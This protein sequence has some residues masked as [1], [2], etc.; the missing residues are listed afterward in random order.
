M[1]CPFCDSEVLAVLPNHLAS[2]HG[3]NYMPIQREPHHKGFFCTPCGLWF[4]TNEECDQ[5]ILEHGKQCLIDN[6]FRW[7]GP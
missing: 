6:Y 5:H 4:D 3:V 2:A 1:K 7:G